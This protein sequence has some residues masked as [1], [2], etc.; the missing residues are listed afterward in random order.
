MR[1]VAVEC[2]FTEREFGVC[3]RPRLRPRDRTYA[4]QYCD[5]DYRVQRGRRERCALTEIGVRYW[6]YLPNLFRWD[7]DR[8]LSPCPFAAV[9]QLARNALAATVTAEGLDPCSGHVL[10]IYDA[11]NPEFLAGGAA[12][13]QYDAAMTTC[14]VPGLIRQ[15]SWQRLAGALMDAPDLA[16]LVA[17]V[18]GK[19]GIRPD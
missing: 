13:R 3:S 5:G 16:Y 4:E 10:V 11:R 17:G 19:Y 7:A 14:R 9:Y 8:N 6:T 12:Q 18:E 15:L 2:K 1:R